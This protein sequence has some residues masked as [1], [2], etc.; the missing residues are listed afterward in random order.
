MS[1]RHV[2]IAEF[3]SISLAKRVCATMK[4]YRMESRENIYLFINSPG[5]DCRAMMMIIDEMRRCMELGINVCTVAVGRAASAAFF[6]LAA[7]T[8]G[9]RTA[10]PNARIMFHDV[11]GGSYLIDNGGS[12]SMGTYRKLA[13]AMT[14]ENS[15][16][17]LEELDEL[18]V[19]DAFMS[20]E[21]AKLNGFIDNIW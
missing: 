1:N 12:E 20:P 6:T 19:R 3:Y 15:G 16:K 21:E 17:T 5:G 18:S 7:G 13:Y 14:A 2:L 10:A 8:P 11:R 4:A 9:C